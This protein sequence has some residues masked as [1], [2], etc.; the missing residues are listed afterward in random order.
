MLCPRCQTGNSADAVFCDHCGM[1]L[2]KPCLNCGEPN[3]H[4]AKFCRSCGQAIS[5][6]A[7]TITILPGVPAPDTYVPKHLAEKILA[8]RHRLE[9][10]RKQVTVLFADI[11]GSTKLLETLDPE[12]AQK[13]I[14]PVLRIMMDA[15]H[16]FEG[17]VNQVLGDGIMA[18]FGAPLAHEDHALRACYAALAMQDEMRRYRQRRG[19]SEES[20]LHIGVGMNSGEVVLRSIDTDLNIDYSALG[21]TTHLAARMQELA[22]PG[23]ALMSSNTLRQVEGFVQVRSLGAVQV[24]GISQP[25][26]AFDVIGSTSA[27]TR[28]QAG[29]GRGLTP[30]VGRS[31]EIDVFNRL[32][33]RTTGGRGQLLAMVGEPGMGKSRLVHEFTRHQLPAGWLVLEAT[34]VSYGK[35]TPYFPLVEMLRRYFGI[36][37][38]EG[39]E[40]IR[41]RVVIHILELDS[42]LKDAIAPILSLLGASP[43]EKSTDR[44]RDWLAQMPEIPEMIRRFNSMDPQQRRRYTLDALKRICIRESQKQNLLL[45]FED[46]HWIDHETQAFL[47][48]LVDSL[49]MA[50]LL[51]LVNYRPEYNHEWSDKSYYTQLH[52]DPLQASSAEELLLKLLGNNPDLSPLKHLLLKRTDGNPFFAEES[53]RSLVETGVLT[54]EKGAYRPGLKIDDLVVPSTVQSVVADRIDRLSA[55]EKHLLQTAAVI[56]AVVP[57]ALLQAVSELPDEQLFQYLAHLKSAEFIYE[58]NLF[59]K[60]EYT[61][62]HALT[63]EVAYGALL[64]ERRVAL[65]ARIVSALEEMTGDNLQDYVETLA[66]HARRGE[67]WDKALTYLREA[68]AKAMLHSALREA[69]VFYEEGLEALKHLPDSRE[70][71]QQGIDLHLDFRNVLF[72]LGDLPRVS[73]HL[74]RAESLAEALGDQ[75]RMARVLNFLNSYYGIVGDPER[76]IEFGQ[77]ALALNITREDPTLSVVT[78]YYTGVAY[79][80]IANYHQAIDML[81][82]GMQRAEGHL[83]SERFG[84]ALVLS[85]ILRSHLVQSL[86]MKGRFREGVSYGLEGVQIAEEVGH[87]ASLIHVNCSLGVLF[88]FQGEFDRA[89]AVLERALKLC[90]SANIPVY[91]PFVASRL[92]SAYVNSGRLSQG[93][94]YLE[95]G[96]DNYSSVGRAGFLSL[97]LAWL[98]EG[99]TLAGRLDDATALAERAVKVSKQHKERGHGVL[100]LKLLGDIALKNNPPEFQKAENYYREA[101]MASQEIGMRPVEAHAHAG[102][103]SVYV[104]T[105]RAEQARSELSAAS[106][107]YRAMQMTHWLPPA[108]ASLATLIS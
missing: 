36:G 3:R 40:D 25:V 37:P 43:D 6:T 70:T 45:V 52:V 84:T 82:R 90:Q 46:L 8:S 30:L 57:F 103:S 48:V 95:Q 54:G 10:E 19:E 34:S 27:R 53:V 62:K 23:V 47:D 35:A 9:G 63:N 88:I 4:G 71:L 2:E 61:F 51:L 72:L 31:S 28:V 60:L 107:L 7:T 22:G 68:G 39:G 86:A 50:R 87:A 14:D 106:D 75:H 77:R 101:L 49:P 69:L 96:V 102:L 38:G 98:S 26:E 83:R 58:T 44:D 93:L 76:A 91:L 67:V 97:S 79:N 104:A 24:K 64:R 20:G 94:D 73:E 80:K 16:R 108:E 13:I 85:V 65:H 55:E 74:H 99:Y 89:I 5:Q 56:G 78:H 41:S 12:E 33:Q 105:G 42:A 1:R 21:H 32:V 17:T 11:K 81:T 66:H 100:A 29:A 92:G 15:V 59:P 18:L